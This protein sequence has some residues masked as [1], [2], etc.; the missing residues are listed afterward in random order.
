MPSSRSTRFSTHFW[1]DVSC[2]ATR[3]RRALCVSVVILTM[4]VRLVSVFRVSD[5]TLI[6]P[7][8]YTD[9]AAY[10]RLRPRP[11]ADNMRTTCHYSSR[12][13]I[14]YQ[15]KSLFQDKNILSVVPHLWPRTRPNGIL[16]LPRTP[17]AFRTK[18]L[19]LLPSGLI[20]RTMP[21]LLG[22]AYADS[23]VR[24]NEPAPRTVEICNWNVCRGLRLSGALVQPVVQQKGRQHTSPSYSES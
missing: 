21:Q 2:S 1:M 17:S 24:D 13:I 15:G 11:I 12:E 14:T 9:R 8:R 6:L 18:D 22:S 3:I 16:S 4:I 7:S 10:F 19:R 23:G 5:G 20:G